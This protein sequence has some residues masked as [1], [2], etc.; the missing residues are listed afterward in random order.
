MKIRA[1]IRTIIFTGIAL[2][3]GLI[4]LLGYFF[5][6]LSGLQAG[7]LK[8]A[9]TLSAV[10]LVVG[11]IN[12]ARTHWR[13]FNAHDKG[14]VYSLVLLISMILTIIIVG[15][16]TLFPVRNFDLS[17]WIYNYVQLPIESSLMALLAVI[18]VYAVARMLSRRIS[19]FSLVFIGTLILALISTVSLPF[20]DMTGLRQQISRVLQVVSIAGARGILL[21]VALGIVATG[22]RI[23]MGADRPYGE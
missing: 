14:G 16:T 11:V 1:N 22:L 15:I 3:S 23:L 2:V 7:L 10:V 17:L 4:V 18:L 5:D 9:A 8:G 6:F 19:V 20:F 12:L 21:G 13:K